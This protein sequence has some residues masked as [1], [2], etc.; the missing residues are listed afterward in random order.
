MKILRWVNPDWGDLPGPV[1]VV[2]A[3]KRGRT[4]AILP[5]EN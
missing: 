1:A 5:Y 4:N 3:K 2:R